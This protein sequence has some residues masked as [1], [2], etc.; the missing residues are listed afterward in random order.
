SKRATNRSWEKVYL[1]AKDR[2]LYTYKDQKHCKQEPENYYHGEPP[3]D[4]RGSTAEI[5]SDYI[6]RRHV[7]RLR[8]LR[9]GEY[10]FQA[11]DEEEMIR[12][13]SH[14][15]QAASEETTG[16]GHS[17]TLPLRR[18]EERKDEQ[19]RRSLFSKKK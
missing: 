15:Q 3:L 17:Q 4:L 1:L 12:W 5:A 6:K 9:G 19:K 10:L 14:L 2:V 16:P 11:K 7:L 8:L 13:L 18:S